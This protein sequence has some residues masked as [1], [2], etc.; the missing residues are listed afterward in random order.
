M[1]AMLRMLGV[2]ARVAVGFTSGTKD[3]DGKW[4]VTDHDAHAWVEVGRRRNWLTFDPTPGAPVSAAYGR[5]PG[6]RRALGTGSSTSPPGLGRRSGAAA[7]PA[8]PRPS[9]WPIWLS[10]RCGGAVAASRCEM[11]S[12]RGPTIR[13]GG[14]GG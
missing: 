11:A 14:V 6:R 8:D 5:L 3:E 7:R 12:P 1:A 9:P 10:R 4:V 2:P 13:A